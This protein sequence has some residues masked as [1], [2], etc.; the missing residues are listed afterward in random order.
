M[1]DPKVRK[2]LIDNLKRTIAVL[3]YV[4]TQIVNSRPLQ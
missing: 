4:S 3:E 2:P 1:T